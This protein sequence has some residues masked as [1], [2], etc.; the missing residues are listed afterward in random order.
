MG[1]K[2]K[3]N[4]NS[5][6][7]AFRIFWSGFPNG[8]SWETTDLQDTPEN[9]KLVE[10]QSVV[11]GN[12]IRAGRFD[13]LRRSRSTIACRPSECQRVSKQPAVQGIAT[14]SDSPAGFLFHQ[15]HSHI[16]GHHGRGARKESCARGGNLTCHTRAKLRNTQHR[17]QC[18]GRCNRECT[19]TE[20]P[21]KTIR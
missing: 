18:N 1:V 4:K 13:Y 7:L 12:E 17:P 14:A 19:K 2:V 9:R 3:R 15:E 5:G 16:A 6:K 20:N 11:I 21:S 8:R 10:A